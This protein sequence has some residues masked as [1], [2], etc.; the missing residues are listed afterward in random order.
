[1]NFI[2]ISFYFIVFFNLFLS[3]VLFLNS[4][5]RNDVKFL[6]FICISAVAWGIG[7][8]IFSSTDTI[9]KAYLGWQIANIGTIIVPVFF[10][11]FCLEYLKISKRYSVLTKVLYLIAALL[12]CVNLSNPKLYLGSLTLLFDQF[13]FINWFKQ[14]SLFYLFMYVGF[15]WFVLIFGFSLIVKEFLNSYGIKKQQLIYLIVGMLIG[16]LGCHGFFLPV[17]GIEIYP[18]SNILIAI[19]TL[20][21]AYGII[22]YRLMDIKIAITRVSIFII[23]Y[24]L[25]LGIPFFVGFKMFGVGKWLYPVSVMMVFATIGPFIYLYIQ[26][27]AEDKLLEEQRQYQTTL[28]KASLGMGR[29]KDLNRLLNLIVHIVSRTVRVEHCKIYLLHG[30]SNQYVLKASKGKRL[31]NPI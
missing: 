8:V 5:E 24:T 29:I 7:G 3:F 13:Y 6:A 31:M 28:S 9:E 20:I 12:L 21:L 4:K 14:K 1:M 11:N 17:F 30:E 23:V 16:F 18:F 27:K 22:R 2:T 19:Y 25:V 10:L 15:Y 26:K